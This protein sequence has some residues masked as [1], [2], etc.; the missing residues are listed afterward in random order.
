MRKTLGD[1]LLFFLFGTIALLALFALLSLGRGGAQHTSTLERVLQ[2]Q[3]AVQLEAQQLAAQ[4]ERARMDAER[5]AQRDFYV[6]VGALALAG[7]GVLVLIAWLVSRRPQEITYTLPA[8]TPPHLIDAQWRVIDAQ[9]TR[10][11]YELEEKNR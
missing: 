7:M 8:H 10:N 11:G 9:M 5:I 4:T 6:F 3:A 2:P 1:I